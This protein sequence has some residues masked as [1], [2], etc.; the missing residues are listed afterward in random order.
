MR[1]T[2]AIGQTKFSAMLW[3]TPEA[4]RFRERQWGNR[5]TR[6]GLDG[7]NGGL[8]EE[9]AFNWGLEGEVGDDGSRR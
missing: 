3:G 1:E 6:G 4:L 8:M 5:G 7:G 9:M 2:A